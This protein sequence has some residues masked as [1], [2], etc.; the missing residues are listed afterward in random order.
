MPRCTF[1][2]DDVNEDI[3]HDERPSATNPSTVNGGGE[4]KGLLRLLCLT[5]EEGTPAQAQETN[6]P[7]DLQ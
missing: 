4:K 1:L 5:L 2:S 3:N 7:T 6:A